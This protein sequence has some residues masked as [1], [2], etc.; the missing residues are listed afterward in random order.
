MKNHTLYMK[1]AIFK[2]L[3]QN[4]NLSPENRNWIFRFSIFESTCGLILREISQLFVVI[5]KC[6]NNFAIVAMG[7]PDPYGEPHSCKL[8]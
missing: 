7:G 6:T 8:R 2:P 1:Y 5:I 4:N 3:Y